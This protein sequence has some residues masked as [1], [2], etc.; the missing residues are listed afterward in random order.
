MPSALLAKRRLEPTWL[1]HP[2]YVET[3]G[4]QV[5]DVAAAAGFAP[6]PEQELLMDL[7]FAIGP[8]GRSVS[9]ETD[10]IA[11]RQVMKTGGIIIAEIGWLFVTKEKLIVHS[12]HELSTT[13]E[14]F[15]DLAALIERT[16]SLSRRLK[17][18]RGDRPGIF[19]GNGRW[20]IHTKDGR[21]R[22]KARTKS[23][24]RGLTGWKVVLDEG[25]ALEPTH[26][27]ALLPTLTSVPDPQVLIASSAG[28]EA[29]A[30][31]RDA[32]DR[33]RAGSDPTQTYAE[34]GDKQEWSGCAD[35]DCTHAKN[36]TGCALD[37]EG[38]WGRIIPG[39]GERIQVSTIR[40]FRRSMP[41][42]EFL[43]EFM[44]W[45]D[46]P[47]GEGGPAAINGRRWSL[48]VEKGG[49]L[50]PDAAPPK[51]ACA[52][53]YTQPDR[54][55]ASIGVAGV[56]DDGELVVLEYTAPGE[57][58]VPDRLKKLQENVDVLEVALHPSSEA[59]TL[60]PALKAES[61]RFTAKVDSDELGRNLVLSDLAA[62]CSS[63]LNKVENGGVVHRGQTAL[64]AAAAV[65]RTK[66]TGHG[67]TTWDVG[68]SSVP[69]APLVAVSTA[70]YRWELRAAEPETPPPSPVSSRGGDDRSS[71]GDFDALYADF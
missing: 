38:R 35:P 36:A 17:P 43:R 19:E 9:F 55:V 13:E 58:W 44:V 30:V 48:P 42:A 6:Y 27:G 2:V 22:Y 45:W 34:W 26:M 28:M 59:K 63:L 40:S 60:I 57:A 16:P 25:F 29:S 31:L 53:L 51:R 64:D 37:D 10:W 62:G 49:L 46:D 61:I 24:G 54:S 50:K 7:L 23:G 18:T 8:T 65:A 11:P 56:N 20:A 4:P 12:A 1:S 32:R 14:A 15:N 21:V 69:L 41:P 3:F 68:S 5:C 70:L 33:G 67:Q 47:E 39:L 71:S 52:V 66:T